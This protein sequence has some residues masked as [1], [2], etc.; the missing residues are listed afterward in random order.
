MIFIHGNPSL[1]I[2][3]SQVCL[4]DEREKLHSME[5]QRLRFL[6]LVQNKTILT[7]ET[8]LHSSLRRSCGVASLCSCVPPRTYYG[9]D[10]L[11][12]SEL[13]GLNRVALLARQCC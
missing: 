7:H 3:V 4:E 6:P 8:M 9:G 5:V 12:G 1:R 11:H 2:S 10:D 13:D